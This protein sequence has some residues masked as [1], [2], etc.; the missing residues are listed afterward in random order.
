MKTSTFERWRGW[1][2][3]HPI[4]GGAMAGGWFGVVMVLIGP[5][6]APMELDLALGVGMAF[7]VGLFFY[8]HLRSAGRNERDA[9]MTRPQTLR[10]D[11]ED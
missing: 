2:L 11:R 5:S 4:L 8:F 7:I 9:L 3:R 1:R 6:T 10:A